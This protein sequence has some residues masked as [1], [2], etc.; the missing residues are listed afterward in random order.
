VPF[1]GKKT[2]FLV[3]Q[4]VDFLVQQNLNHWYPQNPGSFDISYSTTPEAGEDTWQVLASW[5]D[6]PAFDM[7]SQTNFT[8]R[9]TLPST[10]A[11]HGVLRYRY[12]SNNPLENDH[13]TVFYNC[14]DIELISSGKEGEDRVEAVRRIEEG[15]LEAGV[16]RKEADKSCTA[17]ASWNVC[18][19]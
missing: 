15:L 9:V 3:G 18:L 1:T 19:S 8:I 10:P 14:A 12:L 17:P 2:S 7:V 5:G 11:S 4:E 13:G 6:F 16:Q